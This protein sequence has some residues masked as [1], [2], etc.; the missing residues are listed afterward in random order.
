MTPEDAAHLRRAI[1]LAREARA[2]G[3]EAFGAVLLAVDGAPLAEAG[4]RVFT[5]NDLTAHAEIAAIRDA[6]RAHGME[7]L[8][9]ATLYSSTEPCAMCAAAS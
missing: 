7:R 2:R 1:A 3:D 4:N 5:S 8:S 6:A 9:C